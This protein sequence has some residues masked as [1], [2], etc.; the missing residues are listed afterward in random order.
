MARI[1]FCGFF[2][3]LVVFA[4]SCQSVDK[5]VIVP[6]GI[7]PDN[8]G[9]H[10]NAHGGGI[11]EHDGVYYWYGEHKIEGEIGN[12]A[13]V[14]VHCYS[15]RNLYHWQDEGIVLTVS[16]DPESPITKG[17]ILERPKVIYNKQN[18]NYVMWF[19]LELAG[20]GYD[21]AQSG[22]AVGNS[23][24]GPFEFVKTCDP[25]LV[26]GRKMHRIFITC[27]CRIPSNRSIAVDMVVCRHLQTRSIC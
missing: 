25:M 17:C 2:I 18:N 3:F 13:Q 14:G 20:Q 19:H 26:S 9:V 22:V 6:G 5:P 24:T 12:T 4:F 8:Q 1:R 7:W 27:R 11:L 21:A 15:S 23:P 10:I 16:D